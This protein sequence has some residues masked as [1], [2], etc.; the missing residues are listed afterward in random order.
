MGCELCGYDGELV[1]A[2]VEQTVLH[3]C[4]KCS[5]FGDVIPIDKPK[6][7]F[8]KP[9]K[10]VVEESQDFIVSDY[11]KRVKEAR[12]KKGLKQ[13]ELAQEIN[14]KESVIHHIESGHFKP[15]FGLAKKIGQFLQIELTQKYEEPNTKEIDLKNS[16]LTIGDLLNIKKKT[17]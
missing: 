6:K 8:Q 3:V 2:I 12:E 11:N 14:E 10:I 5:N 16:D 7:A 1:D 4:R 9:T 15:S 13:Q 17:H